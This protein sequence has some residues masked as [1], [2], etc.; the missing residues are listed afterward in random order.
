MGGNNLLIDSGLLVVVRFIPGYCN[1][2]LSDQQKL[3]ELIGGNNCGV[4][5]TESSLMILIKSVSGVIGVG[6]EV[7][8]DPILVQNV[9][10][11]IVFIEIKV[12]SQLSTP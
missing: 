12:I 9:I 1:W 10:L 4:K 8:K 3:F 2:L 11:G 5:L 7:K 6:A